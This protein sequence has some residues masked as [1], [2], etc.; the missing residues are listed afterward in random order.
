MQQVEE[1][2]LGNLL[3]IVQAFLVTHATGKKDS[4]S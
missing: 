3:D 4:P 1:L 2:P